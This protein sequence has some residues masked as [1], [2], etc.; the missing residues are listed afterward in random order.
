M[1][2]ATRTRLPETETDWMGRLREMKEGWR[3]KRRRGG[4]GGVAGRACQLDESGSKL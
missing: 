4:S 2:A 3:R 1:V